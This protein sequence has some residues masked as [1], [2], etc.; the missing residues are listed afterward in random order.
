M[1]P[2]MQVAWTGKTSHARAPRGQF[3]RIPPS[4][5]S[6]SHSVRHGQRTAASV[7]MACMS[8]CQQHSSLNAI[9]SFENSIGS[10]A[11]PFKKKKCTPTSPK[12]S[13][14]APLQPTPLNP[15]PSHHTPPSHVTPFTYWSPCYA[16]KLGTFSC[17]THIGSLT[18][19]PSLFSSCSIY[20][21]VC[22]AIPHTN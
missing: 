7:V 4:W 3:L 11:A 1:V 22:S 17:S 16:P 8:R 19:S 15:T 18:L 2:L 6:Y 9:R 10:C 12:S 5:T 20:P 21:E 14:L 13:L